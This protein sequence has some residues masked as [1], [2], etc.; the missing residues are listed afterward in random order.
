MLL[1]GATGS[2]LH[3]RGI[4]WPCTQTKKRYDHKDCIH[5]LHTLAQ[6]QCSLFCSWNR[7]L[8]WLYRSI[9]VDCYKWWHATVTKLKSWQ[10]NGCHIFPESRLCFHEHS[11]N[12]RDTD[13]IPTLD[14]HVG[15]ALKYCNKKSPILTYSQ[16]Q[17]GQWPRQ[18]EDFQ[19]TF[20]WTVF[21]A[22]FPCVLPRMSLWLISTLW[23]Q[24][25]FPA[26]SCRI[27]HREKVLYCWQIG[28]HKKSAWITTVTLG[29]KNHTPPSIQWTAGYERQTTSQHKNEHQ[30]QPDFLEILVL[31]QF[32]KQRN[33]S[34]IQAM[35]IKLAWPFDY[36]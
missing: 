21:P 17:M 18:C 3:R 32:K 25:P 8:Q 19:V 15:F 5:T 24:A 11:C 26:S 7:S 9:T 4:L 20:A 22:V 6:V 10:T 29:R 1:V 23:F 36:Q 33:S 31:V 13:T 12:L 2:P 30:S 27:L 34:K 35:T 28:N 14:W 16:Q